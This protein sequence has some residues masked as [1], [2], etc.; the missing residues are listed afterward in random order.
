MK[1]VATSMIVAVTHAVKMSKEGAATMATCATYQCGTGWQPKVDA[2]IITGA[3]NSACCE[4]TCSLWTCGPNYLSNPEY[5]SNVGASDQVC[6]DR[7]CMDDYQC[8][9]NHT[10]RGVEAR[11]ATVAEC[12]GPTCVLFTCEDGWLENPTVSKRLGETSEACCA[13]SCSFFN[14][15]A[16]PGFVQ[17]PAALDLK[18]NDT[19]TCCNTECFLLTCPASFEIPEEKNETVGNVSSCCAPTC[20]QFTCPSGYVADS[21][22][23]TDFG[24]STSECC[25]ATCSIFTCQGDW[26]NSTDAGKLG[27]TNLTDETCCDAS[28][29]AFACS[30]GYVAKE[31]V[32][33]DA[34]N[35][36]SVCCD[37]TCSIHTCGAGLRKR[38]ETI[39][40]NTVGNTD[41]VCCEPSGCVV[42][43]N[44]TAQQVEGCNSLLEDACESHYVL[45]TRLATGNETN[46][47][48]AVSCEW[49]GARGMPICRN[50]GSALVGCTVSL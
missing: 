37:A 4:A 8:P 24:N 1:L 6:C 20:A 5:G 21:N 34:G 11:G 43:D 31:G 14:C 22:K 19:T 49:W 17:N 28:C 25:L 50:T 32:S 46:T 39:F 3:S 13:A 2:T 26:A 7:T 12:C 9:I 16:V 23:T 48:F 47:T 38:N 44:R 35:T 45:F 15:S 18:G 29:Q 27:S 36:D 42:F 40:N 33:A 30:A 41:E 10:T